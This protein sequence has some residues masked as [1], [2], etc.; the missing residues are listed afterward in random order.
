MFLLH[1]LQNQIKNQILSGGSAIVEALNKCR[2]DAKP[3]II[4][5]TILNRIK[6]HIY[7]RRIEVNPVTKV[8]AFV[9]VVLGV[10]E[11]GIKEV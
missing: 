11:E 2:T 5:E 4:D 9:L 1:L 3:I 7:V 8:V 6:F 10:T